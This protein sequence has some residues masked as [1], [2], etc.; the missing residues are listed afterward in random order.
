[1]YIG[2]HYAIKTTLKE[3]LCRFKHNWQAKPTN[4]RA[5]DSICPSRFQAIKN[6]SVFYHAHS[7]TRS[8]IT[9]VV[10]QNLN[11]NTTATNH[12]IKDLSNKYDI[13][14]IQEPHMYTKSDRHHVSSIPSYTTFYIN[15]TSRPRAATIAANHLSLFFFL[16]YSTVDTCVVSIQINQQKIV[17][18]NTYFPPDVPIAQ[19]L[20]HLESMV[21]SF[22]EDLV[23]CGY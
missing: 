5:T 21:Q 8:T 12:F 15:E 11:R 22:N 17:I 19:C 4:H 14:I 13:A 2:I 9:K 23:I 20:N 1:M 16:Q 10:Q 3:K 18:V 6:A 7:S